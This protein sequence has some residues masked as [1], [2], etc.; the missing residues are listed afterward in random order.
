LSG[1]NASIRILKKPITLMSNG[2]S[3]SIVSPAIGFRE[4]SVPDYWNVGITLVSSA[5]LAVK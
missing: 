3:C 1:I 2:V 5:T 4:T